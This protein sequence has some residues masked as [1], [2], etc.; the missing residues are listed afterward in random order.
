MWHKKHKFNAKKTEVDG[1]KFASKKE[2]KRYSELKLLA[3]QGKI[4]DLKLQPVFELI[5]SF[6]CDNKTIRRIKYI[7]DFY[8]CQNGVEVVEDCKGFRTEVYKIKKKLFLYK[9][10]HKYKLIET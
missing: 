9:Y 2:A 3:S 10:G 4:T 7:A 5:P 6:K 8:Y 1:I